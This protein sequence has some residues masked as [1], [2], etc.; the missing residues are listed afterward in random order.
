MSV[1]LLLGTRDDSHITRVERALIRLFNCNVAVLDY[2]ASLYV[3]E[4]SSTGK[5]NISVEGK[6]LNSCSAIYDRVLLKKGTSF[7]PNYDSREAEFVAREYEALYRLIAALYS[8]L[9]INPPLSRLCLEKP[10]QQQFAASAG[11]EVPKTIVTN[12]YAELAAFAK[13]C[14]SGM[15]IKPLSNGMLFADNATGQAASLIMT[16]Q[17]SY[18]DIERYRC[19]S[20]ALSP[21]FLQEKI[22]KDYELRI[23][24]VN[25][26]IF[27][28]SIDSQENE[29]SRTD[30]RRMSTSLK[31][32]EITLPND[33]ERKIQMTM[34]MLNFTFG[35]IDM[36]VD[37]KGRYWFLECNNQGAW[38][39]LDDI[40]R[41]AIAE[42]VAAQLVE[43]VI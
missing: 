8:G 24:Y 21:T 35:C 43:G 16:N 23:V 11:F 5:I 26:K 33:V 30:W 13:S 39:W 12:S 37:H 14:P 32:T 38:A 10:Y 41:G 3:L 18:E 2:K 4:Q 40:C 25:G 27:S 29:L 1:I 31:Y 17:I 28:F 20:T 19:D 15:I 22:D 6:S 9:I 36:I 34:S 7:F 42:A